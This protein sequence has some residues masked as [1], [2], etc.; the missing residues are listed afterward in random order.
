MLI[1]E[2]VG[3]ILFRRKPA[4]PSSRVYSRLAWAY[5]IP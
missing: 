5:R 3:T 2:A 1:G 4:C